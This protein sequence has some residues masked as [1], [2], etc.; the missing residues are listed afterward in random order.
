MSPRR[1]LRTIKKDRRRGGVIWFF[2]G[3]DVD[4]LSALVLY[5]KKLLWHGGGGAA[6]EGMGNA[7]TLT[8]IIAAAPFRV[9]YCDAWHR[10]TLLR[11]YSLKLE[12]RTNKN[13]QRKNVNVNY[14]ISYRYTY[15]R[16][17]IG[18]GLGKNKC[19]T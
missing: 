5:G 19:I 1:H 8:Y 6:F 10:C 2:G 16:D 9:Y 11:R 3:I 7:L 14:N 18:I 15:G 13:V 17:N 4:L 12:G